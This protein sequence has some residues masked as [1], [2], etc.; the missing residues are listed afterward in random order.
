MTFPTTLPAHLLVA[1]ALLAALLLSF[2]TLF[3]LPGLVHWVRLRRLQR[4]LDRFEARTPPGEFRKLFATDPG[5]SHLWKEYQDTLHIQ[6]EERDGQMVTVAVRSTQSAE[7]FFHSAAVVDARLRSEFFK[8]VPGLFT[9]IGIIGTFGGLIEGLRHF[10]VSD[11]AATVRASLES[12]MHAVGQAFLVSASAI[13]AAMVVTFL[14]KL[15]L[16]S[17]YHRTEAIAQAIDARFDA[18][19]GED[20]LSRLVRASEDSAGQMR[21]LQDG[22]MADV[23]EALADRCVNR[24]GAVLGQHLQAHSSQ[25]ATLAREHQAQLLQALDTASRQRIAAARQDAQLLGQSISDSIDKALHGSAQAASGAGPAMDAMARRMEHSQQQL[26]EQMTTLLSTLAD[27]H[28]QTFERHRDRERAMVDRTTG[29]MRQM[30]DAVERAIVQMG[31]AS[32]QMAQSI[33]RLTGITSQSVDQMH[34]GA[35]KLHRSSQG[36]ASAGDQMSAVLAQAGAVSGQLLQAS[37]ALATGATAMHAG[38][39]DYRAHREAVGQ[40]VSDLRVTVEQA[41]KEAS[42]TAD[43]LARI[44]SSTERLGQAHGEADQYLHGV[45]KVL[46]EAH[47]AFAA[48]VRR[49]LDTANTEFH[50]KL[51]TAVGL[52]ASSVGELEATLSGAVAIGAPVAV[53]MAVPMAVPIALQAAATTEAAA[54]V[55]GH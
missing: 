21:R 22:G 8:H 53:P 31:Q 33:E 55:R 27:H 14:E 23:L 4:A 6:R 40:L 7:T 46:A 24:L 29:E 41:R 35:D 52:L 28:A 1:A 5:L 25:Q 3:L 43:V 48:A 18:G 49:T 50:A 10:Q 37:S 42:L 38:L 13:A 15:L 9:G 30:S 19:A 34:A 36:F 20:Y 39:D 2:V 26:G 11:N 17:L 47:Q 54:V 45:S 51:S 12:L 32:A 44:Q 16:A